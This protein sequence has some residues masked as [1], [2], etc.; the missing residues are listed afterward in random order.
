[1]THTETQRKPDS[2]IELR[3]VQLIM[4]V[5]VIRDAQLA[6]RRRPVPLSVVRSY[7]APVSFLQLFVTVKGNVNLGFGGL[8]YFRTKLE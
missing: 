6:G 4:T 5:I 8:N 1:M 7:S 3:Y 2:C